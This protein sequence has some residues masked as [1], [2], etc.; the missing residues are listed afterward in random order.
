VEYNIVK[1]GA[2]VIRQLFDG[3]TRDIIAIAEINRTNKR[4]GT[5]YDK[6]HKATSVDNDGW[7]DATKYIDEIMAGDR[8]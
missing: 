5:V 8:K 7:D 2:A 1:R 3:Q 6:Q 4:S